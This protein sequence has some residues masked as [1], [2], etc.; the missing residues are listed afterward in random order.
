MVRN[1]K[2]LITGLLSCVLMAC[3]GSTAPVP[4]DITLEAEIRTNNIALVWNPVIAS[5]YA[6]FEAPENGDFELSRFIGA[7]FS[8]ALVTTS[9]H[10]YDWTQE[11]RYRLEGCNLNDC[12]TSNEIQI[13]QEYNHAA[14]GYF[15]PSNVGDSN[16]DAYADH[17]GTA[18]DIE[19]FY[20][21]G[22]GLTSV[23][24]SPYEN[25]N[26][27]GVIVDFQAAGGLIPDN[28]DG[29]AT[30]SGAVYAYWLGGAD[31]LTISDDRGFWLQ[32]TYIKGPDISTYCTDDV[33][34]VCDLGDEFGTSVSM[35]GDGSYLAI[36][37][38]LE[39]SGCI[40]PDPVPDPNNPDDCF[41]D[42]TDNS[43]QDSGAVFIYQSGGSGAWIYLGMLKAEVP[44]EGAEFGTSVDF[45][46]PGTRLVIGAP[47][48]D[49]CL[50]DPETDLDPDVCASEVPSAGAAY[51]FD[52][53]NSVLSQASVLTAGDAAD[54]DDS[55]GQKVVF[56][57]DGFRIAVG[58]PYEDGAALGVDAIDAPDLANG[59]SD[60]G[61]VYVFLNDLNEDETA[62]EW[63]LEAYIKGDGSA[64]S[65]FGSAVGLGYKGNDLI[66]GAPET[67]KAF[68]YFR[69]DDDSWDNTITPLTGDAGDRFGASVAILNIEDPDA[70]SNLINYYGLAAVGA[71][72]EDGS[73]VAMYATADDLAAGAGAIFLYTQ[74]E[75]GAWTQ[76]D[77][78]NQDGYIKSGNSDPGFNFGTDV[79][80]DNDGL[81]MFVGSTGEDCPDGIVGPPVNTD[82][83]P[84]IVPE[85]CNTGGSD[86]GTGIPSGAAYLY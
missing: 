71:P 32:T 30:N 7:A 56:D 9:A 34:P 36:G 68:I 16:A 66:V 40:I 15:K 14:I 70:S 47:Y 28:R 27:E 22:T 67:D 75:N 41:F 85:Y 5:Q 69:T 25:N 29:T 24:G 42:V 55:F 18:V 13:L 23:V 64:D 10:I 73:G 45:N 83:L 78:G 46:L 77:G 6:L 81:K 51:V 43:V 52:L 58:A 84:A 39:D 21:S 49:V 48:D 86:D 4:G 74:D 80:F 2:A 33:V 76:G 59:T 44:Q 50:D 54:T 63:S 60:A 8:G 82:N 79:V 26:S 20:D 17:F 19:K 62:F 61:A 65:G 72:E 11:L 1:L 57:Y 35:S 12:S 37:A 53:T 31:P 3:G 38:P